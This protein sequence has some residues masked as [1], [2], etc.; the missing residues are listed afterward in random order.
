M[1]S[2]ILPVVCALAVATG[3]VPSFAQCG[4]TVTSVSP[5]VLGRTLNP[6]NCATRIGGNV[7]DGDVLR[8]DTGGVNRGYEFDFN[9]SVTP[10]NVPVPL[11]ALD[12][13]TATRALADAINAD[14]LAP[15]FAQAVPISTSEQYVAYMWK[16]DGG[17]GATNSNPVDA[18][19]T[20]TI[21]NF[22]YNG[23]GR[24]F[25]Q[26]FGSNLNPGTPHIT[27]KLVS[28]AAEVPGVVT[29][30]APDGTWLGVS[31]SLTQL[32]ATPPPLGPYDLVLSRTGCTDLV[33]PAAISVVENYLNDPTF[34]MGSLGNTISLIWQATNFQ[35][36]AVWRNNN[37]PD[38]NPTGPSGAGY[39][40]VRKGSADD[41]DPGTTHDFRPICTAAHELLGLCSNGSLQAPRQSPFSTGPN[42]TNNTAQP[43]FRD[44][45][46]GS[47]RWYPGND[48]GRRQMWQIFELNLP[49]TSFVLL[50]G[51]W[52]GAGTVGKTISYGIELRQG[53][54]N[55]PIL[56]QTP[57]RQ[58]TERWDW[59]PFSHTLVLPGGPMQ[60]ACVI[61]SD[62]AVGGN[63]VLHV[64]D[65]FLGLGVDFWPDVDDDGDVDL[66]DFSQFQLCYTGQG[67]V[68]PAN[69][70]CPQLDRDND[71]DLDEVDFNA[72]NA[73][74][75][76][77]GV[78]FDP[79]QIPPGCNL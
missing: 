62:A 73:C 49:E 5:T 56:A 33:V 30:R 72:F 79:N 45:D 3:A 7:A 6:A 10:G 29:Y 75:T 57:V 4:H 39:E 74:S 70:N 63:A 15:H 68:L 20:I 21:A 37:V 11:T 40:A 44:N 41:G 28:G 48:T 12:N 2:A 59:T 8:F 25:F 13:V 35:L 47:L 54:Q 31:V 71:G 67:G 36:P 24:S 76:R 23:D 55:G 51:L 14:A 77:S 1:R 78:T 50:R 53:D 18:N 66:D 65:L 38:P 42:M 19:N 26:V 64:D 43:Y 60:V 22:N 27:V 34:I 17:Y 61:H 58:D 16:S 46:W 32:N 69:P 52:A 9:G